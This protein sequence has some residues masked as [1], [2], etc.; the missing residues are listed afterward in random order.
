MTSRY[1]SGRRGRGVVIRVVRELF[2]SVKLFIKTLKILCGTG[3]LVVAIG[4][5]VGL[6]F[7]NVVAFKSMIVKGTPVI[8][9]VRGTQVKVPGRMVALIIF[10]V[11]SG[12]LLGGCWFLRSAFEAEHEGDKS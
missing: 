6:C 11:P 4:G 12:A 2:R 7:S 1:Q 9:P 3:L 8:C 10:G 5:G